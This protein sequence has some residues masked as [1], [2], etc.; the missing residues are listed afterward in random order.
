[1][2]LGFVPQHVGVKPHVL[3]LAP[4]IELLA[5]ALGQLLVDPLGIDRAV[6]AAIEAEDQLQLRQVGLDRALDAGILQLAR[7]RPAIVGERA[8]DLAERSGGRGIKR[9]L[10]EP[11]A[12]VG[13][14]LGRHAAAHERSAHRRRRGLQLGELGG[15]LLGQGL[16]DGRE[17]LGDLHERALQPAERGA[18]F[19][20][21]LR[22]VDL[23][24]EKT[25][26]GHARASPPTVLDTRA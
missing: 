20:G 2:H 22:P 1:M 24:A 18:Q 13:P 15:V 19:L 8:M 12:P 5:Q 3:G 6:V 4:V 21:V 23:D 7:Q 10:L 11:G 9:E 14:E 17:Q 25:L 26:A 16:G